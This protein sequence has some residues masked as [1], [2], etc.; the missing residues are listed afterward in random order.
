MNATINKELHEDF[1]DLHNLLD[2]YKSILL[3]FNQDDE[4]GRKFNNWNYNFQNSQGRPDRSRSKYTSDEALKQLHNV[5]VVFPQYEN[6]FNIS[7]EENS[8]TVREILSERIKNIE[9]ELKVV[10]E[11]FRNC[12]EKFNLWKKF[13][14]GIFSL[15]VLSYF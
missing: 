11:N 15:A 9:E 2:S 14:A 10:E 4:I 8:S 6:Y 12:A 13:I 5:D 3:R 7:D 1:Q